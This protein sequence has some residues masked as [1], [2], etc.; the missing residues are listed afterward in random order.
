MLEHNEAIVSHLSWVSL[1][2]GF[3]TLGLYIHNDTV[4]AIRQPKTQ[5]L[6]YNLMLE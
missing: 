3:H 5:I 6:V 4:V 2:L 1:F